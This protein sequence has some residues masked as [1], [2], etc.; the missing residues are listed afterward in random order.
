MKKIVCFV[1]LLCFSCPVLLAQQGGMPD[2]IFPSVDEMMKSLTG[3][4]G[5]DLS[6]ENSIDNIVK[7]MTQK[8]QST[9]NTA[10]SVKSAIEGKLIVEEATPDV[11]RSVVETIDSKTKR[12]SPRL[13]IDFAAF[14]LRP[15]SGKIAGIVENDK[16]TDLFDQTN[17]AMTTDIAQ[18]L[19]SRLQ[20]QGIH[21]EFKDR[22]VRLTGTVK[23]PRQRELAE[24]MLQMEPGIDK[25]TNNLA[26]EENDGI[27]HL[28]P[29]ESP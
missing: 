13:K 20:I 24:I 4:P 25:V 21:F 6:L 17:T 9:T 5:N 12:Y 18:R 8:M 26:I 22:T 19:Q 2:E 14:P 29:T 11:N 27:F 15:L 1:I 16:S 28:T 3:E 10:D 23:T 7:S